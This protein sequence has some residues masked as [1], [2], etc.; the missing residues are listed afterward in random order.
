MVSE[1]ALILNY[2]GIGNCLMLL[3]VL[4]AVE[5][6]VP[7]F[8]YYHVGSPAIVSD[9]LLSAAGIRQLLGVAPV[10]WRRTRRRS[11]AALESFLDAKKIQTVINLRMPAD[12]P[13]YLGFRDAYSRR[14]RFLDHFCSTE[15]LSRAPEHYVASVVA[16]FREAG[17]P[18]APIDFRWLQSSF[19]QRPACHRLLRI[20]FYT[21]ASQRVKRWP[22]DHWVALGQMALLRRGVH[23]QVLGGLTPEERAGAV[24]ISSRLRGGNGRPRV[25][26]VPCLSL[27]GCIRVLGRL[28]LL[29]SND[30]W[31]VHAASAMGLPVVGLYLATDARV[32]GGVSP[33]FRAVQS[34]SGLRCPHQKRLTGSCVQYYSR[35]DAPCQIE[36]KPERVWRAVVQMLSEPGTSAQGRQ[37]SGGPR[38]SGVRPACAGGPETCT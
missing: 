30:T 27:T 29:V 31:A 7:G 1:R 37:W 16:V 13:T 24:S 3:P 10:H 28:D 14:L 21:G 2:G 17:L 33:R 18:P 38:I 26:L 5:R 35:C 25:S 6:W 4:A 11:W 9:A 12:H 8:H 23:V 19:L 32:W 22:M 20:G 36:A 34:E 15:H